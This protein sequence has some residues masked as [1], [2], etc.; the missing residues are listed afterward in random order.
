MNRRNKSR[1]NGM[2]LDAVVEEGEREAEGAPAFLLRPA[3]P[4]AAAAADEAPA[5][6]SFGISDL[7]GQQKMLAATSDGFLCGGEG[8]VFH[9]DRTTARFLPPRVPH[10]TAVTSPGKGS[11][12]EADVEALGARSFCP[13]F[14]C[15][16]ALTGVVDSERFGAA[17]QRW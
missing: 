12:D 13:A 2:A 14:H 7:W 1:L 16:A 15:P 4:A 6:A 17:R 5:G 10:E 3:A 11:P 8:F 9:R